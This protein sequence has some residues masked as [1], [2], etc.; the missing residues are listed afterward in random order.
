MTHGQRWRHDARASFLASP[1]RRQRREIL[2][3]VSLEAIQ[4]KRTYEHE[5]KI[6]RVL[7]SLLVQVV[8]KLRINLLDLG[9]TL[10]EISL[11]WDNIIG[12]R[13]FEF[14]FLEQDFL[15]YS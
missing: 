11:A 10:E 13:P 1:R 14:T 12:N 5:G 15:L 2:L 6:A 9:K 8:G 7:E 3:C 4:I